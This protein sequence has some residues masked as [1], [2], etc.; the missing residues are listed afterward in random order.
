MAG[1]D[2][3]AALAVGLKL[4]GSGRTLAVNSLGKTMVELS[5]RT[6]GSLLNRNDCP[7]AVVRRILER[8]PSRPIGE[9]GTAAARTFAWMSFASALERVKK[10]KIVDPFLLKDYFR[11]P[12]DFYTLERFVVISGPRLF[13]AVHALAAFFLKKNESTAALRAFWEGVGRLEETPPFL[14]RSGPRPA[15][16]LGVG[17]DLGPFWWLRNPLGKMMVRSAVPFTWQV[18]RNYVFRSLELK[19]RYDLL[20]LLVRIRL[21]KISPSAGEAGSIHVLLAAAERDPYSGQPYRYNP[22]LGV[23]YSIG[24]DRE[25][26]DGREKVLSRGASDIAI[27]IKFATGD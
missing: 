4:I 22:V 15:S 9:F 1:D 8:L 2:L 6:L 17:L 20:R 24:P 14:W 26:N 13:G 10:D 21:E 3:F 18:L 16:R 7:D 12:A 11:D 19:I 27:T 25:D 5:L 23:I